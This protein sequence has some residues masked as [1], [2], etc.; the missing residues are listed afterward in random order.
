MSNLGGYGYVNSSDG[1]SGSRRSRRV[2]LTFLLDIYKTRTLDHVD[3]PHSLEVIIYSSIGLSWAE[4]GPE[5]CS[6]RWKTTRS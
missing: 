4:T 1:A 3:L 6:I 2:G 5:Y